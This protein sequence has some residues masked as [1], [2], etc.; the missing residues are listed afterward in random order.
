M[1]LETNPVS[2]FSCRLVELT[3]A[4]TCKGSYMVRTNTSFRIQ[5]ETAISKNNILK[6]NYLR[7]I[8]WDQIKVPCIK[9]FIQITIETFVF[10]MKD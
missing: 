6:K 7:D 2:N 8:N 10:L 9:Y 1:A 3:I 5:A 4:S